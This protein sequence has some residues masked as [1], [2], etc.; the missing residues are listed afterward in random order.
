MRI[1]CSQQTILVKYHVLVV[2]FE[3]QQ[4]LKLS[5]LQIIGGAFWVKAFVC[6]ILFFTSHQQSCSYVGTGLPVLNQY[7]VRIN[8]SCSR[9]QRSDAGEARIRRPSVSSQALYN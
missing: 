6:L 7:L 4:H 9:T 2:I 3:K 1:V 5:L 8:V